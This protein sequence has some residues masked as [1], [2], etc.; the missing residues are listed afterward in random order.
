MNQTGS[1]NASW[2]RMLKWMTGF[3]VVLFVGMAI[4]GVSTGPTDNLYWWFSMVFVPIAILVGGAFFAILGYEIDRDA[5]YVRRPG[6]R[7]KI[8]LEGLESI[9]I[10][11]KA[12]KGSIKTF[13]NG[14]LFCFAGFFHNKTLGTW[15][16]FATE[17]KNSVILRYPKRVIVVTPDRPE[18]FVQALAKQT[19]ARVIPS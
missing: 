2:G 5:I 1:Y 12:V 16:A 8:S 14:G 9:E 13:G 18:E 11:P 6:W 3:C 17:W 15:R 4:I 7:S 19:G 10:N